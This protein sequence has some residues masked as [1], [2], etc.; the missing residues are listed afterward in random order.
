LSQSTRES[1]RAPRMHFFDP[2]TGNAIRA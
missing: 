1:K 2:E